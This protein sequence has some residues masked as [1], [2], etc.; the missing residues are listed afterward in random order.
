MA[1]AAWLVVA[2]C[3]SNATARCI[4]HAACCRLHALQI[5]L[6]AARTGPHRVGGRARQRRLKPALQPAQ[7]QRAA[8]RKAALGSC[9]AHGAVTRSRRW[10]HWGSVMAL[11]GYAVPTASPPR[12]HRVLT[13]YHSLLRCNRAR[14]AG[15]CY[16]LRPADR[17]ARLSSTRRAR[18]CS[19]RRTPRPP[20]TAPPG[21]SSSAPASHPA[22]TTAPRPAAC[23]EGRFLAR[24][25]LASSRGGS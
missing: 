20:P 11:L 6:H 25:A 24:L 12:P 4:V 13:A 18:L 9:L 10:A 1:R 14:R 7:P 19:G 8:K 3:L 21:A 2:C 17:A 22:C 5:A 15:G 16:G 23:T